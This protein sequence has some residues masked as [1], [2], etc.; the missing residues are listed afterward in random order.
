MDVVNRNRSRIKIT[1]TSCRSYRCVCPFCGGKNTFSITPAVNKWSCFLCGE[2]GNQVSLEYKLN[3]ELYTGENKYPVF[4]KNME[5]Y[6]NG[7]EIVEKAPMYIKPVELE[8]E[9]YEKAS[10]EECSSVNYALVKMLTLKEEHKKDL[11]RRGFTEE[12]IKKF[13]IVSSPSIEEKYSIP[14]KLI[15][16]GYKLD[17]IPPFYIDKNGKWAMSIPQSSYLCPVYDGHRG[18]LEGFQPRLD[19]PKDGNKYTWLSSTGKKMGASSGTIASLLPGKYDK[20]IIIVEGTLKALCVYCLLDK[21]VT[22]VSAP[23]VQS[24]K[25]LEPVLAQYEGAYVFES[26]DMDKY[27]TTEVPQNEEDKKEH[28]KA[29]RIMKQALK[30]EEKCK[31][32]KMK[33][34]HLTWNFNGK[35]WNGKGKGL[36]DFLLEYK[37]KDLFVSYIIEKSE[38]YRK[39][40]T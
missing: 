5:E 16:M 3:P 35:I 19:K 27:P 6:I 21:R 34:H 40:F 33:M 23:G 38:N 22:V 10:D 2:N 26:Y 36:D 11:L 13:H 29:E 24:I 39:L 4:L 30:L 7:G 12:D 28:K 37:N 17:R 18:L 32:Y 31:T 25:C 20:T 15:K 8:E 9:G 1:S 14:Q